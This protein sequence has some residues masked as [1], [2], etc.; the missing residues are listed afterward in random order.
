MPLPDKQVF[1]RLKR[2]AGCP[3]C[4]WLEPTITFG[5]EGERFQ[6]PSGNECSVLLA[7]AGKKVTEGRAAFRHASPAG[8]APLGRFP[9]E[10]GVR[11]V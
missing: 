8:A 7:S 1:L 10:A 2:K 3:A 4:Q 5:V 11:P 9:E 6:D